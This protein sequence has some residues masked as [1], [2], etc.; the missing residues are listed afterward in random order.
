[1]LEETKRN[2]KI[3]NSIAN[4]LENIIDNFDPEILDFVVVL[5]HL[6]F[7]TYSSCQGHVTEKLSGYTPYV[8]I[9]SNEAE[10]IH[11]LN[12]KDAEKILINEH[13]K[14]LDIQSELLDYL[15][16]FY[17]NRIVT[18]R[19]RLILKT[20]FFCRIS[21]MP[22]F[23]IFA[24]TISSKEERAKLNKTFLEEINAFTKFLE[25]QI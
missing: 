9:C 2:L 13:Y 7:N 15:D 21:I 16:E 4:P 14:M 20:S 10:E 12:P 23:S 18:M 22:Y 5:N 19:N 11:Q 24:S 1:M 8:L 25:S 6:G 17:S 3:K